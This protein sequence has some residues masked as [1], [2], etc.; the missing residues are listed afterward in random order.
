[1]LYYCKKRPQFVG[2][3]PSIYGVGQWFLK[4]E[5]LGGPPKA[6]EKENLQNKLKIIYV[7]NNYDEIKYI[8]KSLF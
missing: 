6:G 5:P 8:F 7:L 4:W 1:M 2:Q 3:S